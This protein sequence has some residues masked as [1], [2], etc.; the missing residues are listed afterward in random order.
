MKMQQIQQ[1]MTIAEEGSISK[2]AKKLFLSQPNLS[3]S[4]ALLEDELGQKIF[5]RTGKGSVI[6]P[7]G[8]EFLS[9]AQGAYRQF[10]LLGDFCK[11]MSKSSPL[12]RFSVASQF[13]KFTSSLFIKLCKQFGNASYEFSFLEGS[14]AEVA[15]IVRKQEAELGFIAVPKEQRHLL[16]YSFE[17]SDLEYH[18]LKEESPA[19]IIRKDHPLC[20]R[21]LEIVS[22]EDLKD[23]PLIIY[24]DANFAFADIL[25]RMGLSP[26]AQK[27]IVRDR[28]SLHEMIAGTDGYSIASHNMNAYKNTEYY[29][30]LTC[31]RIPNQTSIL[32]IG[33][34]S[35]KN[36]PL[37]E[38]ARKYIS[39]LKEAMQLQLIGNPQ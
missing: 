18:L 4:L 38:A 33:Y 21:G 8:S 6:T 28:A 3:T 39:M 30:N 24:Q 20:K 36:R 7:F 14:L 32:E 10:R 17:R 1:I 13:F 19:V 22:I 2:A 25:E 35:N 37:S 27:I 31:L 9:Y 26:I 34:L 11:S 16:L 23:Y 5:K 29:G 12:I 15:D